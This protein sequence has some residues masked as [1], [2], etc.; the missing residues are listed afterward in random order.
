MSDT[1]T[2]TIESGLAAA[3]AALAAGMS[4]TPA[5]AETA[6][7]PAPTPTPSAP[8]Q[9]T[10]PVP[11]PAG[12]PAPPAPAA[13][14]PV[15]PS[16][17]PAPPAIPELTDP[18][19]RRY[20][21]MNGGNVEKALAKAIHDNNRLG[22]IYRE[23]PEYFRPGAVAD[24]TKTLPPPDQLFEAPSPVTPAPPPIVVDEAAIQAQIEQAV[25]Q[26]PEA[27][28]L[29]RSY[30]AN[31]QQLQSMA[32]ERHK[33]EERSTY[34]DR[35]L[36]DTTM[37]P[38][39]DLRR[40]ELQN[41]QARLEQKVM[42]LEARESRLQMNNER[43]SSM[44]DGRKTIISDYFSQQARQRAEEEATTA[45]ERNV[46]EAEYRRVQVEWPSALERCIRDNNIPPEQVEDF[47]ADASRAFQAAM[48]D[49]TKTIPDM[50]AFLAPVAKQI[51]ERLDRYH[52]VRSGQYA[53]SA[54]QR[55][56][57]PSPVTGPGTPVPSTAPPVSP[58][59]AMSQASRMWRQRARA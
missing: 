44:F 18:A 36:A 46:E 57:T 29:V 56:A 55:A 28:S 53:T 24:P 30:M 11:E 58:E 20:L 47:K 33:H 10:T 15:A 14:A 4:G 45:H 34:I 48:V 38:P 42:L 32:G 39:D 37:L 7:A 26:D 13:A 2:H 50:Y 1:S 31:Q 52:R 25:F 5:P 49:P 23:H 17:T 9:Q 12:T 59:E 43:L 35:L 40:G 21:D 8:T 3:T 6:P 16:A 51:V 27:T 22:A 19:A 54:A 41:E